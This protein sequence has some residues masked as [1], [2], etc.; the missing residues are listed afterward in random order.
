MYMYNTNGLF[1]LG[2]IVRVALIKFTIVHITQ[3][4]VDK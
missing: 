3:I 2:V 1:T 4:F